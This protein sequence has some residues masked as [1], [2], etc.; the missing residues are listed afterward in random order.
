[1][2]RHII[3]SVRQLTDYTFVL[4]ME[5]NDL[6]FQSGQFVIL[7]RPGSVTHREYSVY[8]G[9]HDDFLEVLVRE[10]EG[11][12]ISPKLKRLRSGD[13]LELDGPH[14]FFRLRPQDSSG[15]KY[16]FVATGTGISPFHSF[17]RTWP[18]FDYRIIHGVRYGTEAYEHHHFREQNI[19]LC[20][21][22]D[23]TGDFKGR[24][25]DYIPALQI[26]TNEHCFLCGNQ[27]MINEVFDILSG[28]GVPV[29]NINTE[30]Y[31]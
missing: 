11:G 22:G 3:T 10:V 27:A 8:S 4:Q 29:Q 16:L 7:R 15:Q 19:T 23:D 9:E 14:G 21:S 5:R 28:R 26:D 2:N 17:V 13:V 18:E 25:T 31:F 1:V 30:V 12:L 6:M 20:T 24:I